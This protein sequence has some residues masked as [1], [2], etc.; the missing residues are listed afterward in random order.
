MRK[1]IVGRRKERD[2]RGGCLLFGIIHFIP[3]QEESI[4]MDTDV[5]IFNVV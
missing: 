2:E 5:Y 1:E 4:L 3:Q